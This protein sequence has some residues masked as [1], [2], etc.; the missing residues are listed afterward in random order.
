MT[1]QNHIGWNFNNSYTTLSDRLFTKQLPATFSSPRMVYFNDELAE[2]L[3][4]YFSAVSENDKA[5]LFSGN[6]LPIGAA[7]IAQAYAGHQFGHFTMLGDGRAI[8]L[9]EHLTPNNKLFDIQLKGSGQTAYSRRGDGKATL[10]SML[11]EFLISEAMHHLGVPTSR[12]LA[13]VN[14]GEKVYREE[15]HEGAVLPR[16]MSSHIRVGTFE[17]ISN[18]WMLPPCMNLPIMLSNVIILN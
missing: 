8:L 4:L 1:Q 3:G 7:P 9:G 18:F 16:V 17:Y 12:S 15:V 10:R 13:V 14:T 6:I 11:R 5:Q 2:T